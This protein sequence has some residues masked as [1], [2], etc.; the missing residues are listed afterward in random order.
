MEGGLAVERGR[1]TFSEH[2]Q[3]TAFRVRVLGQHDAAAAER[4]RTHVMMAHLASEKQ[5]EAR[6]LFEDCAARTCTDRDASDWARVGQVRKRRADAE[7]RQVELAFDEPHGLRQYDGLREP[8]EAPLTEAGIGGVWQARSALARA[9][10]V[11]QP[12][13]SSAVCGEKIVMPSAAQRSRARS[14]GSLAR[15]RLRP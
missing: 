6:Q 2:F 13:A 4:T 3:K 1:Q 15:R 12:V 14:L 8:N 10:C 11:E 5:V 7:L 9:E